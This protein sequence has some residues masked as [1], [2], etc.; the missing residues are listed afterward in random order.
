MNQKNPEAEVTQIKR[1][2][3]RV[4]IGENFCPFAKPVF[5]ADSIRYSVSESQ[6]LENGLF[7][8]AMECQR[9]DQQPQIETTLLIFTKGFNDF[10]EFLELIDFANELLVSEGYEGVYQLAHFHPDYCFDG[11]TSD[12]AE[13]YTN[14]SPLP[15]LHLL[16]ESSV[17][18]ALQQVKTPE[19][20]PE[21]NIRHAE[22]KGR[23]YW[24]RLLLSC[25]KNER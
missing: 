9:L 8:L 6:T 20:I 7:D 2:L 24:Q 3:E 10:D 15:V 25:V 16:R 14:R 12:D 22:K 5:A 17:E 19:S 4:V 11:C 23:E 21:R 1:W 13:N 18:A